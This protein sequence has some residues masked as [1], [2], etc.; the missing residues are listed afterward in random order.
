MKSQIVRLAVVS[1][2][3]P[4]HAGASCFANPIQTA[5]ARDVK[6]V[7]LPAPPMASMSYWEPSGT[8]SPNGRWLAY[9]DARPK[10]HDRVVFYDLIKFRH[11]VMMQGALS[12]IHTVLMYYLGVQD[13][14]ACAVGAAGGWRVAWPTTRRRDLSLAQRRVVKVARIGRHIRTVWPCLKAS[15]AMASIESGMGTA[16]QRCGVEQGR[17]LS[18]WRGTS[19]AV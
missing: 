17:W 14:R 12:Q 11:W 2:T 7:A 4:F 16:H 19:V 6:H 15:W 10:R 18:V 8:I 5:F 9:F 13:S 3:L 1:C